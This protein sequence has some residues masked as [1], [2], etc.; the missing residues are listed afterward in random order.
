MYI[1]KIKKESHYNPEIGRYKAFGIAVYDK[2]SNSPVMI[3]SDVFTDLR[4]AR[5]F[6]NLCNECQPEPVHLMEICID[7]IE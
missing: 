7:F 2:S 5:Q 4:K 1:F 3:I 6:V